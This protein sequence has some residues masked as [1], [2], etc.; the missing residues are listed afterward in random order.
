M[1]AIVLML[2]LVGK[3]RRELGVFNEGIRTSSHPSAPMASPRSK[4]TRALYISNEQSVILSFI[5]ENLKTFLR[6]LS[7]E[8]ANEDPV[9]TS[10]ELNPI[11]ILFK[12]DKKRPFSN[13]LPIFNTMTKAP[14]S[15]IYEQLINKLTIND[16][17]IVSLEGLSFSVL[18]KEE[19]NC[20]GKD[21]RIIGC[22]DS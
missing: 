10:I 12:T 17:D 19:E 11:G 7:N 9:L 18:I 8:P 4:T 13:N 14:V 5:K 21:L 22:E 3:E 1:L 2:Q 20:K 16:S 6:L 15:T